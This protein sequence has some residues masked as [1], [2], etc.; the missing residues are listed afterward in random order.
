MRNATGQDCYRQLSYG[1]RKDIG[2]K[3]AIQPVIL[4]YPWQ[5]DVIVESQAEFPVGKASGFAD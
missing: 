3:P 4:L 1:I 2:E 5:I